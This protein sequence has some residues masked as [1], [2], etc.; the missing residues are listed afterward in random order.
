MQAKKDFL[1]VSDNRVIHKIPLVEIV[2]VESKGMRSC[3]HTIA[4]HQHSCSK[5]LGAIYKDISKTNL[6]FR[7]DT[8]FAVNL[9]KVVKIKKEKSPVVVMSNGSVIPISKRRK[10]EF[11]KR[12]LEVPPDFK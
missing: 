2:H 10:S 1:V 8:S 3:I 6:F 9:S 5:N 11:F 4:G 12:Y 7:V